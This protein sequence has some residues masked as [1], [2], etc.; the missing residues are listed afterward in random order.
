VR[1]A[2]QLQVLAFS[3]IHILSPDIFAKMEEQGAFSI[4]DAYLHLAAHEEKIIAFHADGCYWRDLGR[5][6]NLLEAAQDIANGKY[7]VT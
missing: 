6:E 1:P 7:S 4:I 3:G 5:P 2:Q